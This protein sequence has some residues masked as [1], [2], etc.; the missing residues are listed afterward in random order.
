ARRAQNEWA[1]LDF[2]Y[3]EWFQGKAGLRRWSGYGLGHRLIAEHLAQVPDETAAS[4]A[5][6]GAE[7]FRPAMRRLAALDAAGDEAPS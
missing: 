5:Q 3:A 4:L 7:T 2:S 1:R 6:T